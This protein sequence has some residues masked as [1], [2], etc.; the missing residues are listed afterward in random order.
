[1]SFATFKDIIENDLKQ[2]RGRFE[3]AASVLGLCNIGH[4][5]ELQGIAQGELKQFLTEAS[6]GWE[7]NQEVSKYFHIF[8]SHFPLL[9]ESLELNYAAQPLA[10][11][12]VEQIFCY[13]QRI[14]AT[15]NISEGATNDAILQMVNMKG[16]YLREETRNK[17]ENEGNANIGQGVSKL[18][19]FLR[20]RKVFALSHTYLISILYYPFNL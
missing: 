13:S 9:T 17:N 10:N 16:R 15:H 11:T 14:A 1:M 19:K 5:K 20:S 4:C 7:E 3:A 8:A 18:R 2:N 12:I 6:T